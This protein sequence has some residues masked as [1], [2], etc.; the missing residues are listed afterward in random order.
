MAEGETVD[1]PQ[2][3]TEEELAAGEAADAEAPPGEDGGEEA[4][5]AAA[6]EE[7]PPEPPQLTETEILVRMGNCAPEP[8]ESGLKGIFINVRISMKVTWIDEEDEDIEQSWNSWE[9]ALCGRCGATK[10]LPAES[11]N[12][13]VRFRVQPGGR[14]VQA[15]DRK[16]RCAWTKLGEEEHWPDFPSERAAPLP[17]TLQAADAVAPWSGSQEA[18]PKGEEY[19]ARVT[20]AMSRLVAAAEVL[21]AVRRRSLRT[22]EELDNQLTKQFEPQTK[23]LKSPEG[24]EYL[25]IVEENLAFAETKKTKF[26]HAFANTEVASF[27]SLFVAPPVG[28]A[29]GATSAAA[30]VSSTTGDAVADAEL[31]QPWFKPFKPLAFETVESELRFALAKAA[32]RQRI[33]CGSRA[34]GTA[35]AAAQTANLVLLRSAKY[36]TLSQA[37]LESVALAGRVLGGLGAGIAVGEGLR[38]QMSGALRCPVCGEAL[39]FG[40]NELRR[41]SR[42]HCFHAKC[43]DQG[44]PEC[45]EPIAHVKS[46]E[47]LGALLWLAGLRDFCALTLDS[48]APQLTHARALVQRLTASEDVGQMMR[49]PVEDVEASDSPKISTNSAVKAPE[50]VA[51]AHEAWQLAMEE[52]QEGNES[53][54][55][56]AVERLLL[57]H[58]GMPLKY[59]HRMWPR[60]LCITST[61]FDKLLDVPLPKKVKEQIDADVPRTRNSLVAGRHTELRRVLHALGAHR[62]EIGYAQGMNQLAAVF[63]KLGFEEEAAFAMMDAIMKA[64]PAAVEGSDKEPEEPKGDKRC[65]S[66]VSFHFVILPIAVASPDGFAART[67][68]FLHERQGGISDELIATLRASAKNYLS[69]DLHDEVEESDDVPFSGMKLKPYTHLKKSEVL[70]QV[71]KM[72]F[73]SDYHPQQ[74]ELQTASCGKLQAIQVAT[75]CDFTCHFQAYGEKIVWCTTEDAYNREMERLNARRQAVLDEFDRENRGETAEEEAMQ[76]EPDENV[77]VRDVPKECREWKS[78]TAEA[79]H[80]EVQNFTVQNS[81]PLLQIMITRT[82][83]QFG[84]STK[85]SD[86]GENINNCRPQKDHNFAPP[87]RE[88]EIGIQAV[89]ETRTCSC[90]TTWFRPINKSTQ[91]TPSDFLQRGADLGYDKVDELSAFLSNVSVG[92]EEALQTNETVDI[93]QEEFAHLGEEEAGAIT[94]THSKLKEHPNFHDVTYT[95]GKRIEWVEWVPNSS[96]MVVS[97]CCENMP[98]TERLENSGKAT[99]STVLVWSFADSLSPHAVLESPWEVTVFKFY[100]SDPTYLIGGLGNGQIAAHCLAWTWLGTMGLTT[101]KSQSSRPGLEEEKHSTIP[102]VVHRQ[103]SMID[104]SHRKAVVAIEFM[105]ATLEIERRGRGAS[106]KNP[107]DAPIKYF[108]TVAGDGQVM[109]WD[110]QAMLDAIND[111]DFLWRPVVRVQLQRQDSGT[112]MGLCHILHCHDRFDEKGTKLL[113]NF[114]A[115]TEEGELILGDWAARGEEDRKADVVKKMYSSCKTFRPMLSLERSPFFPDILL[116][117]TDWAFYLFKDGLSEHLFMSSYTSTYYTRGVWSPT[118]PSVIFLGLVSGGIDIWDFS[119]QSHKASLSDTGAS[120]AITSMMFCYHGE[121]REGQKLAVGDAQ[122]HLHIQNIP[123]NLIKPGGREKENMRKFLDREEKRVRYFQER[124]Q[125]LKD[126]K[127]QLEKQAQMATDGQEKEKDK[128]E[129]LDKEDAIAE[130]AYQKLEAEVKEQLGPG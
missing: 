7:Q 79:T 110:F 125:E 80:E 77:V 54:G 42:F 17:A 97:S 8:G 63:L 33:S 99:V 1:I 9:D 4:A 106:E 67:A 112:E 126:L 36:I 122:G 24:T 10:I 48:L 66:I 12:I 6:E 90:Q 53:L 47:Q 44:C 37:G 62:P 93:F 103:I 55:K 68:E 84:K 70:E 58:G 27:G 100:P 101:G 83:G 14:K 123:K 41:C 51:E 56:V 39:G 38:Q 26:S 113:T 72:G 81:R 114:Y 50:E 119:D 128:T 117:V 85:L 31:W 108:L 94:K 2:E 102:T 35:M 86:S 74:K 13:E 61:E 16:K 21:L 127:D 69:I 46:S 95:K 87:K 25:G 18:S 124:Q 78:E 40:A 96:D 89:K 121:I 32:A 49:S 30:G 76:E 115:S 109:I 130:A 11:K 120:V 64:E 75:S 19:T 28:L 22:L 118:R 29:L 116:G 129:C 73:A 45:D 98:F 60:L 3:P 34:A 104:E 65:S 88:L 92:V 105:P 52:A 107:H 20:G 91:Y 5:E 43:V 23:L 71:K 15:V 82:R 59:R 57:G 111:N